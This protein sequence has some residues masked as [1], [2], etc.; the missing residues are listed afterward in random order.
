MNQILSSIL[1]SI[2]GKVHQLDHMRQL[3]IEWPSIN[4]TL[5]PPLTADFIGLGLPNVG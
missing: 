4:V 3:E 1:R 5:P 2:W